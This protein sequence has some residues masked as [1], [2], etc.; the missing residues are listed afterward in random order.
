M[1]EDRTEDLGE[2]TMDPT[3]LRLAEARRRGSVARSADLTSAAV[4]LG[5][6]LILALLAPQMLRDTTAMTAAMLDGRGET[7]DARAAGKLAGSAF[8]HAAA[9]AAAV[10][11]LLAGAVALAAVVGLAQVGPLVAAERISPDLR[12]I[13]PRAGLARLF[14]GRTG[15]RAAMTLAKIALVGGCG[16]WAIREALPRLTGSGVLSGERLAVETGNLAGLLVLRIAVGL[17]ALAGVDWLY[18]R[19]QHRRDLRTTPRRH[20]EDMRRME[21][22]GRVRHRRQQIG[23]QLADRRIAR[24]VPS[25]SVVAFARHG[26]AVALRLGEGAEGGQVRLVAKGTGF[27]ALRI[28][29][30]AA[31]AGV[32]TVTD[33][34]AAHAIYKGCAR[35]ET[36]PRGLCEGLS[37]VDLTDG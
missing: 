26:P 14:S 6:L 25:A 33:T 37:T 15:F 34:K 32:P 10:G 11:G 21:G 23:Q 30:V 18:Q 13:S 17:L 29:R 1:A 2:R 8:E 19:W 5:G 28:C 22:D 36:V 4:V 31:G 20:A 35:G 16:Y 12:R 24:D 3:P 27:A 9:S 7:L